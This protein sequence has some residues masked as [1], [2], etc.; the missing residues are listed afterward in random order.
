[1]HGADIDKQTLLWT[2]ALMIASMEWFVEILWLLIQYWADINIR[3][4][5]GNTAL[6]VARS[7]WHNQ[8]VNMLNVANQIKKQ[9][10]IK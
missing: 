7:K 9:R 10:A 6:S 3:D 5:Y 1:M 8:I 2:T 4:L